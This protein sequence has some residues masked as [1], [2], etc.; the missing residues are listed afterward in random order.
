MIGFTRKFNELCEGSLKIGAGTYTSTVHWNCHRNFIPLKRRRLFFLSLEISSLLS[1]LCFSSCSSLDRRVPK[2]TS[3]GLRV[4]SKVKDTVRHDTCH[5]LNTH[6]THLLPPCAS[7]FMFHLSGTV[8]KFLFDGDINNTHFV[9]FY[10]YLM[11]LMISS[12]CS[13]LYAFSRF[14]LFHFASLAT[15][16]S[17]LGTR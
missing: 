8:T 14:I 9:L 17:T 4:I 3:V 11:N 16:V 15:V 7:S 13:P 1:M 2:N 10:T 12:N 5:T 6:P